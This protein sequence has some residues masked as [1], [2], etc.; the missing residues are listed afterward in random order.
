MADIHCCGPGAEA[1]RKWVNGLGSVH[2]RIVVLAGLAGGLSPQAQPGQ[3]FFVKQVRDIDINSS[4]LKPDL[5]S[6]QGSRISAVAGSES[7]VAVSAGHPI[8]TVSGK[9]DVRRRTGA[10]LV[11]L[12]SF[13]FAEAAEARG[14]RWMIVRGVSDG[15]EDAL[16]AEV[17]R[18]VNA[19]GRMRIGVVLFN[20]FK[21]PALIREMLRLRHASSYAMKAAAA[22]V[23]DIYETQAAG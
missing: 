1:A 14:L 8:C 10:D 5:T 22:M 23:R 15:P 16:P 4:A 13:A 3:A 6:P 9:R 2:D 17:S 19:R 7:I 21:R 20:V 11:D 18:F 12:E